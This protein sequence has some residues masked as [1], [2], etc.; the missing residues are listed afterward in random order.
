MRVVLQRGN[1]ESLELIYISQKIG[2]ELISAGPALLCV[3]RRA[4]DCDEVV[5]IWKKKPQAAGGW[6]A[7]E[8]TTTAWIAR[9]SSR[10]AIAGSGIKKADGTTWTTNAGSSLGSMPGPFPRQTV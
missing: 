9:L 2:F 6:L 5:S 3:E 1:I 4:S 10:C 8:T 7:S